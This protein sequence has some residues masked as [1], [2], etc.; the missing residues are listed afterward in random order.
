M[1][2]SATLTKVSCQRCR[3]QQSQEEAEKLMMELFL[4]VNAISG[5]LRTARQEIAMGERKA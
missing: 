1:R 3:I 2:Y 5:G 4:T